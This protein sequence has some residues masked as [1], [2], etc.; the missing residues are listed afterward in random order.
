MTENV[1]NAIF[2]ILKSIQAELA[3]HRRRFD[4][5]DRRFDS[6]EDLVRRQGRDSAGTLVMAK[7]VAGRLPKS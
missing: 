1:E 2:E 5:I 3:D 4:Q 7:S 6:L